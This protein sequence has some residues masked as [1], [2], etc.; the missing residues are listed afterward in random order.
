MNREKQRGAAVPDPKAT[1][2]SGLKPG[3]PAHVP[4]KKSRMRVTPLAGLG[5]TQDEI[6]TLIDL[7][8]TALKKH[9]Q[10]ELKLGMLKADEKVLTR[11]FRIIEKGNDTDAGRW[12]MFYLKVRR[13]WHEVQRVIHGYDPDTVRQFVKSLIA[14]LRQHLP[15]KCPACKTK[16]DLGPTVAAKI[17]QLSQEMA[18]KLPA[19]EIVPR[20]RPALAHDGLDDGD[21]DRA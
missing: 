14:S 4:T 6:A 8:E 15:E 16:L 10:A 19:S 11:M 3:K 17:L 12:G 13:G 7:G 18:A 20:P 5:F 1:A 21:G 2:A 9:Y